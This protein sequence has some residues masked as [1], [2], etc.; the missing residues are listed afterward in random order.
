MPFAKRAAALALAACLFLTGCGA[1]AGD[2]SAP[3]PSPTPSPAAPAP[4]D[5]LVLGYTPG[6][7]F[8]PFLTGSTLVRQNAGLLYE[9]LVEIGPDMS[10]VYRLA[11]SIDVLDLQAVI[12]I[13]GGATFADGTPVTAEDAAA[14]IE[15]ARTSPLY[16]GQL[17][18]VTSVEVSDGAVVV[19][20]ARPDS[21]FSY[22]C[23]IP[24]LKASEV[25]AAMPT[26][27]G[28]YVYSEGGVL[29]ENP[30][31]L[32][33]E[34]GQ[35]AE[36][37]LAEVGSYNE[38]VS[39]LT[40]GSLNL[41]Q[42]SELNDSPSG[43]ASDLSYY[44]TNNLIFLG[45]NGAAAQDNAMLAP[46]LGTAAGRG[47]LSQIIDRR[48]LA[49]KGYYSR[50]YPAT[51][52]INSF[53]PCVLAQQVIL[54]EAQH[55]EAEARAA[56]AALGY[57]ENPMDGFFYTADGQKLTVRLLVYSGNTYKRYAASL[58]ADQL[59]AVGIAV[60]LEQADDFEVFREKVLLGDFDLYI[61]EVK[62]YNNMD[63]SPFMEG[64][65]ASAGIV[66]SEALSAAYDAF[67]S[68]MSAAGA[69][70]AAFA[71]EMPFVPLL[72]RNGTV[73]HTRSIR[74]LTSS[75]S[76]VFYSLGQLQFVSADS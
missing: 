75:I 3:A 4:A 59:E 27:S 47:L 22:L 70:E 15:A 9:K 67:R 1:P 33:A 54:P 17:A 65:G 11:S 10:I 43:V 36:I 52:A 39:G 50:A 24:V 57:T 26:S 25:A 23:D 32:F 62:L 56:L 18:N 48:V 60:T 69:Y 44:R 30:R 14:S 16:S 21:L 19:T 13:R 71:A 51:G 20:L 34:D 58:L 31:C 55:T 29:V 40:V 42:T 28:R 5:R 12:H 76:N 61:G 45:V 53:Y 64:G 38:M 37:G 73:V 49:E 72:W 41:Y 46:L 6:D 8:N 66:Q 74:G 68:N 35:P 7:G 63:M 2:D